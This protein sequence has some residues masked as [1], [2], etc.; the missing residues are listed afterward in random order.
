MRAGDDSLIRDKGKTA[1]PRVTGNSQ[2]R[3]CVMAARHAKTVIL[4]LEQWI[5]GVV[6][7][8]TH[9]W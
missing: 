9:S 7:F 4:K 8:H 5:L 3:Y 2:E 1:K 6:D